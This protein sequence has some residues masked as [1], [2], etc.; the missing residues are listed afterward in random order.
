M[1][2]RSRSFQ[3]SDGCLYP[4]SIGRVGI[5]AVVD[6]ALLNLIGDAGDRA[7][8]VGEQ[9]PP[10]VWWHH[11]KQRARLGVVIVVISTVV[12]VIGDRADRLTWVEIHGL[13]LPGPMAVGL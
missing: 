3:V 12:P 5:S 8:G 1:L 7:V 13:F 11:P 10:L 4:V 2:R 6:V 9:R